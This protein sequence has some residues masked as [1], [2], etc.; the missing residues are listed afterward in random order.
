MPELKDGQAKYQDTPKHM[1]LYANYA[2][3]I[4]ATI[5]GGCCGTTS[6]HTK[7]IKNNI[8][9]YVNSKIKIDSI[10]NDLGNMSLGN[11]SLIKSLPRKER[12]ENKRRRTRF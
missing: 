5:I 8:K 7:E 3:K 12:R 4:G 2:K 1:S 10:T 9:D 6:E 11:I